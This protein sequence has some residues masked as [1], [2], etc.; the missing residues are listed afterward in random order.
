MKSALF[1]G[2]SSTHS[3]HPLAADLRHRAMMS[4]GPGRVPVA[5]PG[6]VGARS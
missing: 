4:S 1:S 3:T 6:T 2:R 5:P